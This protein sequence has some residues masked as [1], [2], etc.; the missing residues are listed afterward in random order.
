MSSSITSSPP[1]GKKRKREQ[2]AYGDGE[3]YAKLSR[4]YALISTKFA[5]NT[6]TNQS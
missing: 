3:D 2:L 4:Y 1:G 5:K 6:T